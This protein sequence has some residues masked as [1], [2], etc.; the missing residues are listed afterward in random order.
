MSSIVPPFDDF[1]HRLENIWSPPSR[2]KDPALC[3]TPLHLRV[4]TKTSMLGLLTETHWEC[5]AKGLWMKWEVVDTGFRSAEENMELDRQFLENLKEK[6]PPILHFYDWNQESATYGCF[7]NVK[8]IF[9]LARVK[10]G[11]LSLA[12]RP[13]GGGVLF[14]CADFAFSV[15]IPS[16]HPHFSLNPLSNYH[17]VNQ[18]VRKAVLRFLPSSFSEKPYLLIGEWKK[19]KGPAAHCCMAQPTRY[20]VMLEGRKVA[21]AAQRRTKAGYLHQG[22]IFVAQPP[23]ERIAPFLRSPREVCSHISQSLFPLLGEERGEEAVKAARNELKKLLT[24]YITQDEGV[25]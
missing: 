5:D 21:G 23:E 8:E 12:K 3:Q 9:D 10:E 13:T 18:G 1:G 14:H 11:G 7:V 15:L 6:G 24:F 22:T 20:D 2:R 19:L 16:Q 17:Y 4:C 25:R